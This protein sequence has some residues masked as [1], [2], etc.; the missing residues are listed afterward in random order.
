MPLA[1]RTTTS[2]GLSMSCD[3]AAAAQ[4][5]I[6]NAETRPMRAPPMTAAKSPK[7]ETPP[8]VPCGTVLKEVIRNGRFLERIPSS[9]DHVSAVADA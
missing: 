7:M 9:E 2:R 4:R 8:L 3:E 5:G 6:P 1:Q